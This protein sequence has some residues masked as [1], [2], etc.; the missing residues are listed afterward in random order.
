[1]SKTFAS[2]NSKWLK[3]YTQR[4]NQAKSKSN[5]N[6]FI[7]PLVITILIG[8]FIGLTIAN[9]GLEDPQK[10]NTIKILGAIGGV[11]LVLSILLIALGKKKVVPDT[12]TTDNL[13]ELLGSAEE[14]CNFDSQMSVE[15][16]FV[17]ENKIMNANVFATRDYLG[18]KYSKLGNETYFFIRLKDIDSMHYVPT[19]GNGVHKA[20]VVDWRDAN[21]KVLTNATIE[22][23]S[24]LEELQDKLQSLC[25]SVKIVEE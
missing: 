6:K 23:R 20:Y 14:V 16:V 19:K 13:N 8:G 24:K 11:M 1:M 2:E 12:T 22:N 25:P 7:I 5:G 17:I 3:S 15:P 21:G 10:L 9:G 4:V 18:Q